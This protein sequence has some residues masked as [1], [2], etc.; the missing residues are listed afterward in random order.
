MDVDISPQIKAQ[1]GDLHFEIVRL[2]A[3][4]E[5]LTKKNEDLRNEIRGYEQS[6]SK[7]GVCP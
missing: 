2:N 5:F 7:D 1:L 4:V 3:I 6:S